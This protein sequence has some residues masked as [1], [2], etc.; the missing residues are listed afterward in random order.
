MGSSPS[1]RLQ[2]FHFQSSYGRVRVLPAHVLVHGSYLMNL[3]N[4]DDEKRE[5]SYECFL[6]EIQRCEQ[7]G[8]ELYN[9]HPGSTVGQTTKEHSI[10]LIAECINR[11]HKA[12]ANLTIVIE[13]MASAGNVIGSE[14]SELRGIIDRVENKDRVGVICTQLGMISPRK[15]DGTRRYPST[16][17]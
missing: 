16:T 2:H 4:P 14:F 1:N 15:R 6:D 5:K 7:L 11:A 8:L 10:A 3:G 17:T 9:F 12:T 13:N